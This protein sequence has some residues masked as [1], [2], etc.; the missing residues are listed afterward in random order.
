LKF[1]HII[2][3]ILVLVVLGSAS[4][5]DTGSDEIVA[6][7]ITSSDIITGLRTPNY[8]E[9]N[10]I[11]LKDIENAKNV[12]VIKVHFKNSFRGADQDL[13]TV[14][15]IW[16]VSDNNLSQ[17]IMNNSERVFLTSGTS[18]TLGEG[19]ELAL[20]S[21]DIDG[22][23]VFVEL[24]KYGEVIDSRVIAIH[25]TTDAVYTYSIN[26]SP[27]KDVEVIKV[28]FKNS[29]RGADQ[30]LAI[31]DQIWQVSDNNSSQV[32]M[33]DSKRASLI[34]GMPLTL[35][36]GYELALKSVDIDGNK[37][38]VEL[39]KN[40]KIIDSM[41]FIPPKTIDD[42]YIYSIDTSSAK[43]VEVIKVH[44]KNSFRGADQDLATVDQIWQ[45]SDNNS[46]QVIMNDS[47]R[48][49]LTS[50]TSLTLGEGYE[51]ALKSVDIDG[52]KV[53]VELSK[54]GTVIDS[55]IVIP[56]KTIDDYY[57][58]S[59]DTSSAKDV[60]VIKVHFKNSFRGA[61][62]DL[63]T[64]DQ[65]WQVSDNNSSQ[66]IMNHSKRAS[67]ISGMPLTLGEGYELAP[68]SV[69]IDGNKL[70]VELSKNGTVI[71]SMI[72]I[73]PQTAEDLYTYSTDINSSEDVEVIKV[74][75]EYAFRGADQDLAIV[76]QIWQVSDNNSSQV[77][78]ND[79]KRASLTSGTPLTLGEGYELALKSVDIDGNKVY[80]ELSKNGNAI[81]SM[82]VIPSLSSLY[83][84]GLSLFYQGKNVEAI[85]AFDK[86]IE[87]DPENADAWYFKGKA[88]CELSKY[89]EAIQAYDRAVRVDPSYA[90]AWY[91]KGQILYEQG[92]YD[93]AIKAYDEVIRLN[94]E[95]IIRRDPN[96][97]DAWYFKGKALY[98]QG[99]Y[100]ESIQAYDEVIKLNPKH[101]DA[102]Y[103]KGKVLYE[104]GK[105][106]ESIQAYDEAIKLNPKHLDAWYFKGKALYERGKY[107]EA[108]KA[109]DEAIKIDPSYAD[110]WYDKGNVLNE[111][112]NYD[113]AIKCFDEA[114]TLDALK[115]NPKYPE[116]WH[117]KGLEFEVR[118]ILTVAITCYDKA[119]EKNSSYDLA[120]NS[121][122]SALKKMGRYDEADDAYYK[123]RYSN[124]VTI[125]DY[126]S[127][128][129]CGFGVRWMHTIGSGFGVL[130]FFTVLYFV[131]GWYKAL[132]KADLQ[133]L[134]RSF[135]FS[136]IVLLSAPKELYPLETTFYDNY[137]TN[138]KYWPVVERIIGWSL[139]ILLI[140]TLSRVMIRY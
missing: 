93:E 46:S 79:S 103:Y 67:L 94:P 115:P 69:D 84:K 61:D 18:L 7:N 10:Y 4:L 120:W 65:I 6:G 34:S 140:N 47:K 29:F 73:P 62:Q 126:M 97:A 54:N 40:G 32:I 134:H 102:W 58:Y 95:V 133:T 39:S 98:E 113:E 42:Y 70:Y 112:G 8:N 101:L 137:S 136:L 21:I 28:H 45:V 68:K 20:K 36:E 33:N 11:F 27:T 77:I 64:V 129:S 3:A 88:L 23:K 75:F 72:V 116:V 135:W 121:K 30:D 59:I 122:M 89:N 85:S 43:D 125:L 110:P 48:A 56:P 106:S 12:D 38:Y 83:Q 119:I 86:S 44:F 19:Y 107:N 90:I 92:E 55:M 13:A 16:Q 111:Q 99:K 104:E 109:Y 14:D 53:Y 91:D 50:G 31:L 5:R 130:I 25:Q 41:I 118:G 82:V 15:Q 51:L 80:V 117:K 2:A 9:S 123:Y 124:M 22:N 17:V 26:T 114:I 76:D 105:H 139:L 96:D 49:S 60:E 81:D 138:I 78:M 128:L 71:D 37:M 100:N 35:G 63:A 108:L 131:L 66:V 57:I 1:K 87:I 132:N 52:N 24:S 127:W 74:L